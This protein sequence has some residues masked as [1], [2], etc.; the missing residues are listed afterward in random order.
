MTS[1][2]LMP[3]SLCRAVLDH[4]GDEGALRLFDAERLGDFRRDLLDETPS[5]PRV[6]RP[7][8]FELRQISFARLIGMAKPMPMLPPVRLKM[9]VL[10]PT[11]SPFEVE[12]GPARVAGVDRRVGLDEVVVA[13]LADEARPWR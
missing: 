4:V 1:P 8:V 9:A 3:A 6:T 5:Q 2:T 10:M 7:F 13:A 11:T 12:Q